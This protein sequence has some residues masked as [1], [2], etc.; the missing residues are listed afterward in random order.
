V[1]LEV[2]VDKPVASSSDVEFTLAPEGRGTW[3]TWTI[4]GEKDAGGKAFGIYAV[5]LEQ[6]GDDME[7]CLARLKAI[8]EGGSQV[9]A[10]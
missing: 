3:V 5:P 1:E 8:V 9:A 6:L 2:L 4:T 10:H 7:S